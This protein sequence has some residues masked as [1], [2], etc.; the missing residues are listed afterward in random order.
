M[1]RFGLYALL[2]LV[3]VLI[4]WQFFARSTYQMA[5]WGTG[6]AVCDTRTGHVWVRMPGGAVVDW[7]THWFPRNKMY[8]PERVAEAAKLPPLPP[9]PQL[10]IPHSQV[11]VPSA[12]L[13]ARKIMD[14]FDELSLPIQRARLAAD[15]IPYDPNN[16]LRQFET[17]IE[18]TQNDPERAWR[19]VRG[20][21]DTPNRFKGLLDPDP[22]GGSP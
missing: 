15:G 10:V 17:F 8:G 9:P 16:R 21:M 2:V 18:I 5:I 7:G 20:T 4:G 6:V 1:R 19:I 13:E 14:A 3:G 12:N 11:S 22:N